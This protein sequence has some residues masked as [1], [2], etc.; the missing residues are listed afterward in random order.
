MYK[1]VLLSCLNIIIQIEFIIDIY[2]IPVNTDE[3]EMNPWD[4]MVLKS[5][6]TLQLLFLSIFK[7]RGLV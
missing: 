5:P 2:C 6:Q 7:F 3:E 1:M 4:E